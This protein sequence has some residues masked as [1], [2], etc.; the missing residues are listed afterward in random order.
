MRTW[1]ITKYLWVY[2]R[3]NSPPGNQT[4]CI[5]KGEDTGMNQAVKVIEYSAYDSA[6]AAIGHLR[7]AVAGM[8]AN[9]PKASEYAEHAMSSTSGFADT[10]SKQNSGDRNE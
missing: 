7:E 1:E 8:L 4:M 9:I 5:I 10:E 6:L 3:P 2:D